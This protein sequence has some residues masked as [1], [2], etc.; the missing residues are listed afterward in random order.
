MTIPIMKPSLARRWGHAIGLCLVLGQMA[1]P[2]PAADIHYENGALIN[3]ASVRGVKATAS[4]NLEPGSEP[5]SLLLHRGE[6][7]IRYASGFGT[8]WWM[9]E[10]PGPYRVSNV[11]LA[12]R[13]V[14]ESIGFTIKT[15][16]ELPADWDDV[17]PVASFHGPLSSQHGTVTLAFPPVTA[18]F[19]RVEIQ[20]HNGGE[21]GN[22]AGHSDL[23]IS[24][25]QAWGPNDPVIDPAISVA[26]STWAGGKCT[27]HDCSRDEVKP[28][29]TIIPGRAQ[30][31]PDAIDDNDPEVGPGGNFESTFYAAGSPIQDTPQTGTPASYVVM[32]KNRTRVE[33]VGYATMIRSRPERPRDLKIYTSAYALGDDWTLQKEARDIPGGEYQEFLLDHPVVAQRVRFDIERVWNH[34]V[35]PRTRAATGRIAELYVYGE[36]LSP[37]ITFAVKDTVQVSVQVVDQDRH[38]VRTLQRPRSMK[39]GVYSA[40]WDGLSDSGEK[41][42]PGTYTVHVVQNLAVYRNVGNLGNTEG[43]G[44]KDICNPSH[45]EAITSDAAG[46]I[47]TANF[48]EEA[49]QDFREM[50]RDTGRHLKDDRAAIRNG[51]PNGL[52]YAIALDDSYVYCATTAHGRHSEQH[53]RRFNLADGKL[54]PFSTRAGTDGHILVHENSNEEV[55]AGTPEADADVMRL[56]LRALAVTPDRLYA[57]D[58]L[59]GKVAI[60]DKKTGAD[61]GSFDVK[62]PHAL[63]IDSAGHLWV[64][65]EHGK[66]TVYDADGGNAK[67]VIENLGHIRAL[68][69][70]PDHT[71]YVADSR[72]N[73]VLIYRVDEGNETATL[74]RTFGGPAKPGDDAPDKFYT[75][76]GVTVDAQGNLTVAQNLPVNGSRCTRFGPDGKV[77]WDQIGGEF[78]DAGNYSQEN[79]ND[80]I[81]QYFH[82]YHV[83]KTTG[84][85]QFRGSVLDGNPKFVNGQ[86]GAMRILKL[87]GHEL[88]FQGYYDALQVYR[89]EGDG[90][91][92]AALFGSGDP[93]PDGTFWSASALPWK[94]RPPRGL[95]SWHD[96]NGNGKIDPDEVTWVKKPGDKTLDWSNFGVNVDQA[97]N[98]IICPNSGGVLEVPLG[99]FDNRGNPLYD[100]TR[101]KTLLPPDHSDKAVLSVPLMAVRADDGSLY[102]SSRSE[103][104]PKPPEANGGWM[105]GWVL[106]RLDKE[107]KCLWS[108]PLPHAC[109]GMDYIPGGKGV[110]LV[111]IVWQRD[112]S[113]IYHYNENGELVGITAPAQQFRGI[114]GIPDNTASMNVSRDP[115]DG[116]LD[117]FVEDCIGNRFRWFRVDDSRKP[118]VQNIK[119]TLS[120]PGEPLK[121]SSVP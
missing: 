16:R 80:V 91:R 19:I 52:P 3:L 121:I 45:I 1:S 57:T 109:P 111:T 6:G 17:I 117:L 118:I 68:A 110:M 43:A 2:L 27:E 120:A 29:G 75:L 112:G 104:Y 61:A 13:E 10:L 49:G 106:S 54:A 38:I 59:A 50:D 85:W 35:D 39:P 31:A 26:Q 71:L 119:V 99:G 67:D 88:L 78:C 107:G 76:T 11:R 100:L 105:C 81:S 18:R 83:D 93:L 28:D 72:A 4:S 73:Q 8:C 33:A 79:P 30:D 77:I 98:A 63:A 40:V 12:F 103:V 34:E 32:L 23:V 9:M 22:G 58:A 51:T 41:M 113:E 44:E 108:V 96:T 86:H 82:R 62:L 89:R 48:W 55:A 95:W 66:V 90:Y 114:G 25:F 36:A 97:G 70:G 102:V 21:D 46:N 87:N 5:P 42:A 101:T 84:A 60:Y 115:H 14:I 65:H 53:I 7:E 37:D 47:F 20:G 24:G 94:D 92:L 69:M 64:G 56:P 15:A 116:Q 74:Q